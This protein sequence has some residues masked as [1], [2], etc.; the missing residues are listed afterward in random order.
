M[1]P[2]LKENGNKINQN[3][4]CLL[5]LMEIYI[6]VLLYLEKPTEMEFSSKI[7]VYLMRVN[8]IK[9]ISTAKEN[10]YKKFYTIN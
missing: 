3:K 9:I 8:L 4:E 5:F 10:W 7:K 1:E 2:F 6:M